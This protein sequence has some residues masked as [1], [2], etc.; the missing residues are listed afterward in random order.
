MG[1]AAQDRSTNFEFRLRVTSLSLN[2]NLE[3]KL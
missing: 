3:G 2:R 1:V